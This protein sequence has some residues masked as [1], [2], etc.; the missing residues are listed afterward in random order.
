MDEIVYSYT[1][2]QAVEDGVLVKIE[3]DS[4]R[5]TGIL[6]PV[7]FTEAVWRRYVVVPPEFAGI[8]DCNARL[9]DI[10]FMFAWQ[11]KKCQGNILKFKFCCQ[12]PAAEPLADNEQRCRIGFQHRDISL[13]AVIGPQDI[14]DAS[15][16]IFIMLPSED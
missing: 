12:V 3:S 2:K 11:A 16:A 13:K 14:N 4:S 8:Q 5:R 7:Y 10:L 9:A 1:T 6:F 15:P